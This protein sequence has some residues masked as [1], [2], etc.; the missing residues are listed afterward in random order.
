MFSE[1]ELHEQYA[2]LQRRAM[3]LGSH[4]QSRIDQLAAAMRLPPKKHA[5]DY[6]RVLKGAT[7]D[8]MVAVLSYQRAL[9]FL[10]TA[11]SLIESL[12]KPSPNAEDEEWREQLLFRL[13]EV[14]EI[15]ADLIAEGEA[16]LERCARVE[17]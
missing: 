12:A 17:I 3:S 7:D 15:G 11:N 5:D 16:H 14:L 13:A 4:G 9:P 6:L 1:T 2:E 8:A 10:E